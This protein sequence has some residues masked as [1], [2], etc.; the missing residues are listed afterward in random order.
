[1]NKA[2]HGSVQTP[3]AFNQKMNKTF[4]S[5]GTVKLRQSSADPYLYFADSPRRLVILVFVDDAM[6]G[7][8]NEELVEE[9]ISELG[10]IFKLTSRPLD[11]FLGM[12]VNI[13]RDRGQIHIHQAKYINELLE[14]FGMANCKPSSTPIDNTSK[15]AFEGE[16]DENLKFRE[17][18]GGLMYASTVTRGDI[19]YATSFL[20]RYLERPTR[21]LWCTVL[22]VFRYLSATKYFGPVYT[23]SESIALNAY[24][25]ADFA[26]CKSTFESTSGSL[27]S[28][29]TVHFSGWKEARDNGLEHSRVG[30]VRRL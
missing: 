8:E 5:M 15:S 20:S 12:H 3:R 18:V 24:T 6:V 2:L 19:Q 26:G 7:G 22:K 27:I 25:D 10:K 14:R 16:V 13:S 28:F 9:F 30:V 29:G 21:H 1:M 23:T 11:Y 17:A 4:L